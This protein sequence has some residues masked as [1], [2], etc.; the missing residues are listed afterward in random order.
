[1]NRQETIEST[2]L[3]AEFQ[4]NSAS[5]PEGEE[6]L[7]GKIEVVEQLCAELQRAISSGQVC[8]AGDL[9]E[10]IASNYGRGD[11]DFSVSCDRQK[12]SMAVKRN[13]VQ[14]LLNLGAPPAKAAMIVRK[15]DS[16]AECAERLAALNAPGRDL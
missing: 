13:W 3:E 7:L 2:S 4:R 11:L 6:E 16:M 12:A 15:C 8:E 1:M 9:A 14:Q 5:T 10:H